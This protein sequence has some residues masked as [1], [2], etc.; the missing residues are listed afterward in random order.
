MPLLNIFWLFLAP[1]LAHLGVKMAC[2]G[3]SLAHLGASLGDLGAH[4]VDNLLPSCAHDAQERL[5][6][7]SEHR[8]HLF[9]DRSGF[10]GS[11]LR[12]HGA[13]KILC[14]RCVFSGACAMRRAARKNEKQSLNCYDA[15]AA[16]RSS[17][18][19]KFPKLSKT[20]ATLN[21]P[22]LQITIAECWGPAVN[23]EASS[24]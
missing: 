2:V 8:F 21:L 5:P 1:I 14:F 15:S 22:R 24:I 17:E 13:R 16:K 3:A 23:R 7:S 9:S 11:C 19:L 10:S 6:D 12:P 4:F 20:N 18:K